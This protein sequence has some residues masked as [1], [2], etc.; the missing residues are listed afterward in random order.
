MSLTSVRDY[1]RTRLD[2]LGFTEWTDGFDFE[3]VPETIID[4]SYHLTVGSLSLI[5]SNHTVDDINY[6]IAI[7]LYLKGFRDPAS[8]IDESISG[9]DRDWETHR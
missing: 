3:Y 6:P 7:G 5:T 8:A 9:T 2:G 4:G 1:F